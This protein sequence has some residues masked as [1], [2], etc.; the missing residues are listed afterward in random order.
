[1][2]LKEFSKEYLLPVDAKF[3]RNGEGEV[4]HWRKVFPTNLRW[5]NGEI[6]IPG[7]YEKWFWGDYH[8]PTYKRVL[9]EQWE[10][11][12]RGEIIDREWRPVYEY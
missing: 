11:I 10:R 9:A 1:M 5:Q 3:S 2:T 8:A 12:H 4:P 6:D 7:H